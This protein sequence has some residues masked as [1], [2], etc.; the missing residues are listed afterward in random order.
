VAPSVR[1]GRGDRFRHDSAKAFQ[2]LGNRGPR[3]GLDCFQCTGLLR[4]RQL[5]GWSRAH[6]L[7]SISRP[8]SRRRKVQQPPARTRPR[9]PCCPR[10]SRHGRA[11]PLR[12][13]FAAEKPL[14]GELSLIAP[15]GSVAAKSTA[16][17]RSAVFLAR[18]GRF[19]R[20]G[21]LADRTRIECSTIKR[22]IAV[23][24]S[25]PAR[26][27]ARRRQRLARARLESRERES[28]LRMDRE[29]VRRAARHGAVVEGAARGAARSSAQHA[30]QPLRPARG[31]D[32][33]VHPA[34][35]RRPAVLP[36]RVFRVQDGPAVRIR[37]VY[38]GD[39]VSRRNAS[40][41]GTS[42]TRPPP[43]R[44]RHHWAADAAPG[45][46]DR[47]CIRF[48]ARPP[49]DR[50]HRRGCHRDPRRGRR[51]RRRGRLGSRR[52]S[53]ITCSIP[54]PTGCIPDRDGRR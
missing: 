28:V 54:S 14:E 31:P 34:R 38:R 44:R 36:A 17:R 47:R 5:C 48:S 41:G 7:S 1:G 45:R 16:A 25:Q 37:E 21:G 42:S 53:A 11:R 2:Y 20:R 49:R 18:R 35:L 23:A 52:G 29:A 22:E 30:V 4:Q 51:D 50:Q 33:A 40:R 9:L 10:R 19:S 26:C 15:D 3:R 13:I 24:A 6:V 32:R 12:V 43:P 46:R 27:R 39:A 8:R